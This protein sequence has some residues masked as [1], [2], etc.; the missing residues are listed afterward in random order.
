MFE[1]FRFLEDCTY[2]PFMFTV[3][4]LVLI[5]DLLS[6]TRERSSNNRNVPILIVIELQY[7]TSFTKILVFW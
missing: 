3:F 6:P 4:I 7:C 2:F 5:A 1:G